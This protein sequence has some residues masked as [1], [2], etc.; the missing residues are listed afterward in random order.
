[1]GPNYL[2]MLEAGRKRGNFSDF[3]QICPNMNLQITKLVQFE[4]FLKQW[5]FV[6]QF[7]LQN[8]FFYCLFD[9]NPKVTPKQPLHQPLPKALRQYLRVF[10]HPKFIKIKFLSPF[11]TPSYFHLKSKIPIPKPDTFQKSSV[12]SLLLFRRTT[13]SPAPNE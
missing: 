5:T 1:M 9:P 8:A 13:C 12:F 6:M 7:K 10:K 3:S 11:P 2:K 4:T